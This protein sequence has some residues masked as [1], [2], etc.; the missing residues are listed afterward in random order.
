MPLPPGTR[1]G[2]YEIVGAIGSGGMG[3][4]YRAR[5]PRLGRDVAIKVLPPAVAGDADRLRRF[6]QEART[7]AALSHP[8]IVAIFD[9]GA[10]AA[11]GTAY[12]VTELLE[13]ET[14]RSR[15]SAGPIPASTVGDLLAQVVAGLVAAHARGVV[16][17]DLKPENLFL[18]RDGVVKILDFGLAKKAA[19]DRDETAVETQ[20]SA[21]T[22]LGTMG[23]MAPEQVRGLPVDGRAD[24]FALGAVAYEILS[25]RRAFE[26]PSPA[27]T[28]AAILTAE[29]PSL[30][31]TGSGRTSGAFERIVRRCL[32]KDPEERFQSVRDLRFA[33]EAMGE[34]GEAAGPAKP[35]IA[36]LPF[37]D[38][39]AEQNQAY[40]CEGMAEEIIN[41]LT[42]VEGLRV[43]ARTS[44]FQFKARG[45]D[46]KEIARALNVG[47]VLEGSVRTAGNRLRVTAQ[48]V[49]ATDGRGLW[50]DRYDGELADVFDIQDRIASSLVGALRVRLLGDSSPPRSRQRQPSNLD[51]YDRYLKGRHH[52]FTTYN[53]GEALKAF[54]EAV[55][56]DPSFAPA[57]VGVAYTLQVLGNYGYLPARGAR[58]RAEA[59][60][61]Q[62]LALDAQL[63]SAH[64]VRAY[65][66]FMYDQ[67][68]PEAERGLVHAIGLDPTDPESHAYYAIFLAAVGRAGE[69]TRQLD[70]LREIDPYS[71]WSLA[72]TGLT[73]LMLGEFDRAAAEGLKAVEIRPDAVL[74][75]FVA[76]CA[77]PEIGRA[78]EGVALLERCVDLAGSGV[79]ILSVLGGAY[80]SL[81]RVAEAEALLKKIDDRAAASFPLHGWRSLVLVGLGRH[82]EAMAGLELALAHGETTPAYMRTSLWQALRPHPR[83]APLLARV[84]LPAVT[85]GPTGRPY[86][87]G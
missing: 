1:L 69:A 50:S 73:W 67:Q 78:N 45:H 30:A 12:V 26:G 20:T 27:D 74:A 40:F 9:T 59:S 77:L 32:K 41:A 72:V 81:G 35:S 25:G 57:H 23:Y 38:M 42:R 44:A 65:L 47:A 63:P 49:D 55:Q 48:L 53:L 22:V 58:A 76:G 71:A 21:G 11:P 3:E 24:I 75:H 19:L 31:P 18:T 83:F 28:M 82:D 2:R 85:A 79:W 51:A 46:V 70:R 15:L 39:S 54:E 36:V 37:T 5:D 52:R 7:V 86:S 4:V 6:E 87:D 84:G 13:G 61:D 64:A 68:W 60:L 62:A 34:A 56:L 10:D 66:R 14:L 43:A 16:H 17:R 8:N 29:P 33:L 80:G